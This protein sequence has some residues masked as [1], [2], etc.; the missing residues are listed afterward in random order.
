MEEHDS[1]SNCVWYFAQGGLVKAGL[2]VA[3]MWL[4]GDEILVNTIDRDGNTLPI[5]LE[6]NHALTHDPLAVLVC[7]LTIWTFLD[8]NL[9]MAFVLI[10]KK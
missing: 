8:L 1:S 9:D 4:D 5:S 2:D 3:Q 7:Y 10:P 6:N